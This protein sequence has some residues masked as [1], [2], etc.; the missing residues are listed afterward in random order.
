M[1]GQQNLVLIAE[2][3]GWA[4]YFLDRVGLIC[5]PKKESMDEVRT[6][7][8]GMYHIGVSVIPLGCFCCVLLRHPASGFARYVNR[9]TDG[10]VKTFTCES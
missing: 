8:Y 1:R 10:S 3:M 4:C 2:W 5:L 7:R 6:H 9:W